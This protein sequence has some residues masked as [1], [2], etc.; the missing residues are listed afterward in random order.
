MGES[1][2]YVTRYALFHLLFIEVY[3][4]SSIDNICSKY[5]QLFCSSTQVNT[6]EEKIELRYFPPCTDASGNLFKNFQPACIRTRVW[7]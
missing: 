4:G 2:S 5:P 1:H 7:E 3:L 6:T